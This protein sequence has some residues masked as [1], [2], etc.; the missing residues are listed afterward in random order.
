MSHSAQ[1]I[2]AAS[3]GMGLGAALIGWFFISRAR[4]GSNGPDWGS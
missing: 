4:I 2:L 3:H 1:V